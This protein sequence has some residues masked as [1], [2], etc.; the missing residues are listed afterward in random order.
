[1]YFFLSII[2]LN[3]IKSLQSWVDG[4]VVLWCMEHL[5]INEHISFCRLKC[6]TFDNVFFKVFCVM[7]IA[8]LFFHFS[9]SLNLLTT[10]ISLFFITTYHNPFVLHMLADVMILLTAYV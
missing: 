9:F 1:M 8:L 2:I 5:T 3:M 10:V 6:S 7:W 4:G